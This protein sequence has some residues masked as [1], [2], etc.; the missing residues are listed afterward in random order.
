MEATGQAP[1][2]PAPPGLADPALPLLPLPPLPQPDGRQVSDRLDGW[3][4]TARVSDDGV[5]EALSIEPDGETPP[6]GITARLLRTVSLTRLVQL[7]GLSTSAAIDPT[8]CQPGT[9]E[10]YAA[11]AEAYVAAVAKQP[12]RPIAALADERG[13][14]RSV[15]R[16]LIHSCRTHGYLTAGM[17]GRA[18]GRLSRRA[19]EVLE[20]LV[21][22]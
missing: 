19:L 5:I 1:A 16:D 13:L 18:S 11:W 2:E 7:E 8:T 15:V 10:Y 3:T 9:P 17:H 6:G 12:R 4:V 14:A 20:Q 21:P 22:P